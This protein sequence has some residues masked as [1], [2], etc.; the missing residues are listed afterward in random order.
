MRKDGS[1]RAMH[2]QLGA[3]QK[4]ARDLQERRQVM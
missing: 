3:Q 4:A 2:Q 1:C